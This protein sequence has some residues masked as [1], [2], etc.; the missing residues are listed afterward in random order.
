M[1]NKSDFERT[2]YSLLRI[3]AL[4][5]YTLLIM[6]FGIFIFLLPNERKRRA[7]MILIQFWARILCLLFGIRVRTE[8][9]LVPRQDGYLIAAN[10]M[11]YFDITILASVI[12]GIFISKS[13]IRW[14][15]IIGLAGSM[16]G[17]LYFK[18]E[19]KSERSDLKRKAV[20]R[21]RWGQNI[22]VFPE[23]TTSNGKDLLPFRYGAFDVAIRA[24]APVL[25]VTL[26]YAAPELIEWTG[27]TN[28]FRHILNLGKEGNI[29]V[30]LHIGPTLNPGTFRNAA[31]MSEY[32]WQIIYS[33]MIRYGMRAAAQIA[34][35]DWK[36]YQLPEKPT[37]N[38]I[39][40]FMARLL[41]LLV[42]VDSS[43]ASGE[44]QICQILLNIL[45]ANN[46]TG[47]ILPS[48]KGRSNLVAT[49][50]NPDEMTGD[51]TSSYVVLLSNSDTVSADR[52]EWKYPPYSGTQDNGKIW[53]RGTVDMKGLL[54]VFFTAF[55]TSDKK[56]PLHF[57]CTADQ[58]QGGNEGAKFITE[59]LLP[60]LNA[61][62]LLG[63]GGFG[64]ADLL[65]ISSPIFLV[66]TAEKGSLWLRL[67][68]EVETTSHSAAPPREYPLSIILNA[69]R[70]ATEIESELLMLPVS[71]RFL[72]SVSDESQ[73]LGRIIER[74][75]K[76]PLNSK[77]VHL[78]FQDNAFF[79]AMFR[80]TV[81]VS[82]ICGSSTKNVLAKKA[83]AIL[84]C[85]LL[86][87][88]DVDNFIADLKR[89]INDDRVKIEL[90][91][92]SPANETVFSDENFQIIRRAIEDV[93]DDAEVTPFLFP[94]STDLKY[95]RAHNIPCFGIFPA[96]FSQSEL[97]RIHGADEHI[98]IKQLAD[99]Y[100][101]VS[102]FIEYFSNND[103]NSFNVDSGAG[104]SKAQRGEDTTQFR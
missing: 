39:G 94:A 6:C 2:L 28:L 64:V 27:D 19:S 76:Q 83:E 33:S 80:N 62:I 34:T 30:R 40:T 49:H 32:V 67:S 79:H 11:S 61:G 24:N 17:T 103:R 72:Q 100:R 43:T 4:I 26:N 93:F 97:N 5:F 21:L 18:R 101:V 77:H 46:L 37:D 36:S 35:V 13:E 57:L 98:A 7:N 78:P 68:V 45:E 59:N 60:E 41:T 20:E 23:G 14:W 8:G 52:R 16:V 38:E 74:A 91:R 82:Q 58:E 70:K 102:K 22:F 55:L 95:F 15:P 86:P 53:G 84:D 69:V 1:N 85:R 89:I 3:S 75:L 44:Q 99:A 9:E 73:K 12:P 66:D 29:D 31:D 87:G 48:P 81:A 92:Q 88:I 90:I 10:H 54:T 71:E 42:Q 65:D 104:I 56:I 96:L 51:Q 63:E 25:P 47:R 50:G